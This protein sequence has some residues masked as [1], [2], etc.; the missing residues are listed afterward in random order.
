M[1]EPTRLTS[2]ELVATLTEAASK[3]GDGQTYPTDMFGRLRIC[4][5]CEKYRDEFSK[6]N[7]EWMPNRC[8]SWM[9]NGRRYWA[10]LCLPCGDIEA[11]ERK[12]L[13][14]KANRLEEQQNGNPRPTLGM[15]WEKR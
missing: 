5:R 1:T 3:H 14:D 15:R 7:P 10:G 6:Y 4:A 2:P 12:A 11:A 9:S 13:R 8:H